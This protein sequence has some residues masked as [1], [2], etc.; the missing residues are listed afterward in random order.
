MDSFAKEDNKKKLSEK[1]NLL[2]Q[3]KGISLESKMTEKA[4]EKKV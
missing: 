2:M 3:K 1:L 4:N